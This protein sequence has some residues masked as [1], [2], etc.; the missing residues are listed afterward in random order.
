MSDEPCNCTTK[1]DIRG[2]CLISWKEGTGFNPVGKWEGDIKA[3]KN[4]PVFLD[5]L[6]WLVQNETELNRLMARGCYSFLR[7]LLQGAE[8]QNFIF[9]YDEENDTI[10]ELEEKGT[11]RIE[12][13][14]DDD[15]E[16][17][18]TI[19]INNDAKREI[20]VKVRE[21]IIMISPDFTDDEGVQ[22]IAI[23]P[24]K[25][26]EPIC[27]KKPLKND[28]WETVIKYLPRDDVVS[29]LKKQVD[30]LKKELLKLKKAQNEAE[31]ETK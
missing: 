28:Q 14:E 17:I 26:D 1:M 22:G 21:Q 24:V 23:Y 10:V 11:S 25:I 2:R 29:Q 4:C 8:L 31:A 27:I 18:I 15:E 16:P 20:Y 5:T 6:E 19:K 9:H 12:L 7:P 30:D 13:K 3:F